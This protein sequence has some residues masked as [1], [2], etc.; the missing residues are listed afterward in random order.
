M[1]ER[2]PSIQ[3]FL[4]SRA[5]MTYA[6]DRALLANY[7]HDEQRAKAFKVDCITEIKAAVAKLGYELVE[8]V[9]TTAIDADGSNIEVAIPVTS[10]KEP[11]IG[12]RLGDVGQV[13]DA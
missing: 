11:N 12:G 6:A 9:S 10:D 5:H 2:L 13:A 1:T 7:A 8:V 4:M 3:Q